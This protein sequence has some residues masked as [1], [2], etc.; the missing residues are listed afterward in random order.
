[1]VAAEKGL[2]THSAKYT[3]AA[4]TFQGSEVPVHV[5]VAMFIATHRVTHLFSSAGAFRGGV[6]MHK[7]AGMGVTGVVRPWKDVG[8]GLFLH[9]PHVVTLCRSLFNTMWSPVILQYLLTTQILWE[10]LICGLTCI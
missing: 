3:S 6:Q 5:C 1:M 7:P 10:C 9:I 4:G 2:Q 8:V